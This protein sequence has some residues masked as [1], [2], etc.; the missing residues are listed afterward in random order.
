MQLLSPA[1]GSV[2]LTA[3]PTLKWVAFPGATSYY[4]FVLNVPVIGT[5]AQVI[6]SQF[7]Q[8]TEVTVSPM[9]QIGQ[10]YQW[11][12]WAYDSTGPIA[13]YFF[14]IFTVGPLQN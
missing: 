8:G 11:G 10:P 12:V 5:S 1:S 13:Y 6:F 3:S 9:L 2:T 14:S 7:T 4:V